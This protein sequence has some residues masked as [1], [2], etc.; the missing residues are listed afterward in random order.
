[1]C[2]HVTP[3][4]RAVDIQHTRCSLILHPPNREIQGLFIFFYHYFFC[5]SHL[6]SSPVCSLPPSHNSDPGSHSRLSSPPSPQRFV[7][8]IFI[9]SWKF[10]LFLP[11]STRR[12]E[13]CLSTLA[14]PSLQFVLFLFI[15]FANKFR[16]SPRRDSNSRTNTSSIRGLLLVH[17]G[18]RSL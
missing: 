18:D 16:I 9:A 11:S 10:Q 13:L 4:F 5:P 12:V 1:M 14:R 2:V 6:L 8:C 7:P 3:F 17:R 15:F